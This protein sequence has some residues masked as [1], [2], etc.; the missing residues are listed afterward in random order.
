MVLTILINFFKVEIVMKIKHCAIIGLLLLLFIVPASFANT[1]ADNSTLE[2]VNDVSKAVE[3]ENDVLTGSYYEENENITGPDLNTD[4]SNFRVSVTAKNS[5]YVNSSYTGLQETGTINNPFKTIDTAFSKLSTNRSVINIF[6]ANGE[7]H[8]S[9]TLN[10]NKNLNFI[11]ETPQNTIISA[12][13]REIFNINNNIAINIFNLTLTGGNTYYGGAIYNNKSSVNI[14]NSIL[15]DNTAEGYSLNSVEYSAAGGAL[16]CEAGIFRIY[17]CSFINNKAFSSLNVYGGAIYN[18]MGTVNIYNSNF[19]NH[20]LTDADYGCGG[21][22]YNFNGF[23]TIINS[24]FNENMIDANYSSGS[25]IYNYEAHNTFVINS[26][27]GKN[28]LYGDY[29]FGSPIANSGALIE[30][31]NSTIIDNIADGIALENSSVFNINGI[32]NII[33]STVANNTIKDPRKFLLMSLEDQFIIS[34]AFNSTIELPSKYDLRD[35]GL[36]TSV[37]SQGSSGACWTFSILASL[38]SF[39]L[40]YENITCDLSENN[41]K[42]IMG[43]YG[44][45]GTDWDDGGNYQMALAYLLRWSGPVSEDDDPFGDYSILPNYDLTAE[46]H[47]QGVVFIPMRMGHLDNNQIK[48]ALMKYGA[49]YTSI[50]GV[51]IKQNVFHKTPAIPNHAVAI[52][53][54]DDNYPASKFPGTKPAG[55]GAFII[56]NSWGTTYGEKGYGYVSYYDNTFA[57]F[58]LDSISAIAFTD[59]ENITNYKDIYQYDM[60]GNTYESLGFGCSTAW[61]ANQFEAISDNPISAFGLYAYGASSYLA[62]IYVNGELT[63]SQEGNIAY[64]GY[65]TIKLNKLIGLNMGDIF[66]INLKL[67]TF[68]SVFPIAVELPRNGYSSKASALENQSFIS[69]DGINWYDIAKETEIVKFADC[70]Y[71]KTLSQANVCLKV[72]TAHSGN[73]KLNISSSSQYFLNG[74]EITFTLNLTNI[75]D[76]TKNI[77][78]PVTLDEIASLITFNVSKGSY[79]NNDWYIDGLDESECAILKITAKITGMKDYLTVTAKITSPDTMKNNNSSVNFNLSYLGFTE[80]IVNDITAISSSNTT[81]NITLIDALSNPVS[82]RNMTVNNQ[83]YSTDSNGTIYLTIESLIAGNFTYHV[84]FSGDDKYKPSNAAFN[85][86]VLKRESKLYSSSN[87]TLNYGDEILIVVT[88][89]DST[90][91]ENKTADIIIKNQNGN[92]TAVRLTTD[93]N[94]SIR[95]SGLNAGNYSITAAFKGDGVYEGALFN[96]NITVFKL[97]TYIAC[98]GLSTNAVIVKVDGYTGPCLTATLTDENGNLLVNKTIKITFNSKNYNT[99]TD[100]YGVAKLQINIAKSGTYTAKVKFSGDSNYK[101]SSKT[102]KITIKKKKLKLTVPKKTYKASAKTK[103]LTATLKNT[104]NKAISG[105]KVTFKVNGKKY[106]AK[107]NKNG[108]ATVKVKISKKKTYSVTATFS[109]DD[110]YFKVTKNGKLIIK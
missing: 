19:S 110:S 64:A 29:T 70:F 101:S 85:V 2:N 11:G 94:G 51:S 53:G 43:K 108:I 52:V 40:K 83:I 50:D 106:S 73:L 9:N 16:Y 24:T 92:V 36:V 100:R 58:S 10:L 93:C 76:F 109:G 42:N 23:L 20:T 17:N 99:F 26:S 37:K 5:F 34:S 89:A 28:K 91:L 31:I 86:N 66:R 1:I 7:Y 38:E 65:H 48:M 103:K 21:V 74:D 49:L 62:D 68:D 32:C 75:G 82:N 69:P 67:T 55:D 4:F 6:I 13:G 90:R 59:V 104:K 35:E 41:M 25:V 12:N 56:K 102:V 77:T 95:L 63:Y 80:I 8:I 57:G 105:K 87:S 54:W 97:D 96:F 71:N 98:K 15:K 60:L 39:L 45:N 27:F 61:L 44:I 47:V 81:A 3:T 14:V 78:I 72:Y 18:D 84:S 107:T 88:D 33:N 22:I 30:I 79:N 46:K